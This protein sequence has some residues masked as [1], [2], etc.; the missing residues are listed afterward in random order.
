MLGCKR[1]NP[2]H[3]V[4]IMKPEIAAYI[5]QLPADRQASYREV[6]DFICA[7][8]A[9]GYEAGMCYGSPGFAVPHSIFPAGYHCDPKL[10]LMFLSL[11]SKKSGFSL[12]LMAVYMNETG[13]RFRAAWEA[14]GKKLDM[15]AACIRFKKSSDIAFD[16][17]GETLKEMTVEKYVGRYQANL[18]R[19]EADRKARKSAK[20][21]S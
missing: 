3:N 9:P 12:H 10:P 7:N 4:H 16:V 11:A 8:I 17:L 15:G 5:D 6:W 2:L 20:A 14:T 13:D 18:D 1:K 19:A 21:K